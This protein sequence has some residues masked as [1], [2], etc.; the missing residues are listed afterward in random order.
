[1]IDFVNKGER[2]ACMVRVWLGSVGLVRLV[3]L[4]WLGWPFNVQP[5]EFGEVDRPQIAGYPPIFWV[6]MKRHFL[7]LSLGG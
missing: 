6:G 4:G 7:R 1:V 3:G 5:Y 2:F